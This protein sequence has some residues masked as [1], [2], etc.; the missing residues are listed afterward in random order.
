MIPN[1]KYLFYF[2]ESISF[3]AA[4]QNYFLVLY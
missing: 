2:I 1:L 4:T 3:N